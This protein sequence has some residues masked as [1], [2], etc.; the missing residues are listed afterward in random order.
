MISDLGGPELQGQVWLLEVRKPVL[1]SHLPLSFI[2]ILG[3]GLCLP[4]DSFSIPQREAP[5]LCRALGNPQETQT[6]PVQSSVVSGP[7]HSK[8]KMLSPTAW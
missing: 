1:L 6:Q 2:K 8:E 5:H 3:K 4:R 7:C